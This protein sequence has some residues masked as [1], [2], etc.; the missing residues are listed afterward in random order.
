MFLRIL[1]PFPHL[2]YGNVT[3]ENALIRQ[4]TIPQCREQKA[5]R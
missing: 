5:F 1:F 2:V 4:R 3:S